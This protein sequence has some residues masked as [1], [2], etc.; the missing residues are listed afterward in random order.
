MPAMLRPLIAGNWKMNGS[1]DSAVELARAVRAGLAEQTAVDVLLC[2]SFVLIDVVAAEIAGAAALLLGSQNV[3]DQD[4]GAYT[5]E[6]SASM[7][8]AAGCRYAIIGHSE[9][10]QLYAE[11]DALVARRFA[12]ARRAGLIPILCVGETLE[13]RESGATESV[14]ERQLQAVLALCGAQAFRQ[15]VVAYEPVWAIGT[16]MTASPEQAQAVHSFIRQS[17]AAVDA[18]AARSLRIIYGGSMKAANA[19]GL[20]AM[21]DIDGGLIGGAALIADEFLAICTAAERRA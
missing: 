13:E 7:L 11:S 1:R 15:A 4:E 8:A 3:G 2:P 21:K 5:G 10:R 16:G 14:I 20:L 9:R 18:E 6:V 17:L 19:A 12:A